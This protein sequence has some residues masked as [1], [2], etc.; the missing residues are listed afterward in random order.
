MY[1]LLFVN[2]I[3]IQFSKLLLLLKKYFSGFNIHLYLSLLGV[4]LQNPVDL[5]NRFSHSIRSWKSD[6]S[7]PGWSGSSEGFFSLLADRCLLSVLTRPSSVNVRGEI[8]SPSSYK[9]SDPIRLGFHPYN[10]I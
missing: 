10:L 5:N 4:Q 1:F 3:Y 2:K 8:F 9:A 7:V 6:I